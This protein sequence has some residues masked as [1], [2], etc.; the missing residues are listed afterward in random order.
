MMKRCH[1]AFLLFVLLLGAAPPH[2]QTADYW[3]GYGGTKAV[4]AAVAA[5]ALSWVETDPIGLSQIA[6]LG[7]KTIQYTDPNRAIPGQ[8]MFPTDEDA[9][10]HT[11]SGERARGGGSQYRGQLLTNPHSKN[12]L[13]IW[14]DM[15]QRHNVRGTFTAVF[16][17]NAVGAANA[18]D[19]PCGYNFDDWL[20]AESDLQRA[21]GQPVIYN[22]L[23]DFYN[24]G[25]AREIVLNATALGGMMENCYSQLRPEHRVNGWKW[26]ATEETEIRMAEA[27]KYFFCYGNDRT[28]ADQA[29]DA[30]L[31]TFASF[32]L[33]YDPR[34][35]VLW[36][37]YGTPSRGHV[38]P[39]S[40]VVAFDPVV[41]DVSSIDQLRTPGGA[42]ARAY[43]HCYIGGRSVGPCAAAVNPDPDAAHDANLRGYNHTLS[44]VGSGVFDGGTIQINGAAPPSALAPLQGIVAF[45]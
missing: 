9:F 42:Y 10:A 28:P 44:L 21:L 7:V 38:M 17:D 41:P 23:E 12:L 15:V 16:S 6:P 2:V 18:E 43:K 30:R 1:P 26:T 35:T 14:K 33:T 34:T 11:C 40:R 24:Q 31:Y 39:E 3:A 13:R 5:Q 36:E 27:G 20:R 45:K 29:Y 25:V 8:P 32:L 22:G 4:P 19:Q 37:Y